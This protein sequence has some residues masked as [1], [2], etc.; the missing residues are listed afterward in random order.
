MKRFLIT[1]FA[2]MFLFAGS[3]FAFDKEKVEVGVEYGYSKQD[4]ENVGIFNVGLGS[5][6]NAGLTEKITDVKDWTI[7]AT[8]G[9]KLSNILTPYV[10][11]GQGFLNLDQEITGNAGI[12]IWSASTPIL[13]RE[14]RGASG[15]M[16]GAGAKGELYKFNNGLAFNYDTRWTT[17]DTES[18]Q[19][20]A[21]LLPSFIGYGV[22]D[23]MKTSLG[24]FNMDLVASRY[25]DLVT[26]CDDGSTYKKYF[27]E[28]FT[29][30]LGGRYTH[31][32]LNIKNE[33]SSGNL[34]IGTEIE[35]QGNMFSG[36]AGINI[37]LTKNLDAQIGGVFGQEN[38]VQ[39]KTV[40]RF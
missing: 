28:G 25:F 21:I 4:I 20:Q 38:G 14:L 3:A 31:S 9:Y 33:L 35:T 40:Y 11:L 10:I 29:P 37:K 2:A 23:N 6:V 32:D 39:V 30:F 18:S 34:N 8:I 12:G 22:N 5:F 19:E 24:V 17:F 15:F 16:Y 26:T 1:L 27:I 13:V 7:D 36:L